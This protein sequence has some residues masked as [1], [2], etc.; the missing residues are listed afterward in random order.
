[1]SRKRCRK[2]M[3]VEE[4]LSDE[5]NIPVQEMDYGLEMSWNDFTERHERML[6]NNY[7]K[8][9]R[10]WMRENKDAIEDVVREVARRDGICII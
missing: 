8:A 4:F 10:L 7:G 2:K 6:R 9:E 1:M 3:S 5:S